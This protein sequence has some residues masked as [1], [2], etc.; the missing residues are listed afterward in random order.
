M[1]V[2]VIEAER[3]GYSIGQVAGRAITAGEMIEWLQQFDEDSPVI[4][5]NDNGYTYGSIRRSDLSTEWL[6]PEDN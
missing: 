6:D 2:A 3:A 4:V 1:E 5:S